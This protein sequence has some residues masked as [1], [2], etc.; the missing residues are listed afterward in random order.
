MAITQNDLAQRLRQTREAHGTTQEEVA[1]LLGLSRSAI[2]QIESGS[3]AVSSLELD[4]LSRLHGRN[5]RDFFADA[6]QPDESVAALFRAASEAQEQEVIMAVRRSAVLAREIA[7]LE[8]VLG[9]GRSKDGLPS[10]S[11]AALPALGQAVDQEGSRLLGLALEAYGRQT[12]SQGKLRELL[13]LVEVSSEELDR[14][15]DES[16]SN[17]ASGE[18]LLPEGLD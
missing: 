3:R 4:D 10:H 5:I 15:L 9:L 2:A 18:V 7:N 1:R 14:L 17:D 16:D 12:I 11:A 8:E 13:R 6:F